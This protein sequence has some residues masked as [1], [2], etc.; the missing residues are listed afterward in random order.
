MNNERM[1]TTITTIKMEGTRK[2]GRG[3]G[4]KKQACSG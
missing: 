2:R 3:N 4:N 1:P